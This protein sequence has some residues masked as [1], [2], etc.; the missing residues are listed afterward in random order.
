MDERNEGSQQTPPDET[1]TPTPTPTPTSPPYNLI[2]AIVSVGVAGVAFLLTMV[3]FRGLIQ[4]PEDAATVAGAL[5]GLFTLIG[6][7]AGAY[8]GIKSTQDTTDKADRR[9]QEANQR[10]QEES[11]KA[12]RA[13]LLVNS[14]D[15]DARKLL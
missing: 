14:N 7:V 5:G 4:A 3:I 9:T 10:T 1:P 2:F 8:F 13:S 12:R 11:D 15:P 6:T